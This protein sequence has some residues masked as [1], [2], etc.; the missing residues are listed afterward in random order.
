[1]SP[2]ESAWIT[3]AL[4]AKTRGNRGEIT[5]ISLSSKPERFENLREVWLFGTG[6]RYEVE[7]TWFHDATLIFKFRGVDSISDAEKLSGSEVRVPFSERVTL[8]P[9]E[10]FESDIVG[11]EVVDRRTG[12]SLGRV[13][14]WQEGGGAGLLAVGDLL[15]PFVRSICVE[16][17]PAARHI[18]VELPEGLED[19]N[20]P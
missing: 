9:G 6:E 2:P 18:A 20:R 4:L 3:V 5:A 14:E 11:C 1:M 10:F 19:L 12:K 13:R 15:I 7:F 16:I 8:D 17:D